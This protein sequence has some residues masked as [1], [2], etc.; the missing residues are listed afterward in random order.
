MK[1]YQ[2]SFFGDSERPTALRR[3]GDPLME[4]SKHVDFEMF[5]TEA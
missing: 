3:L 4:L 5:P 1:I 2:S